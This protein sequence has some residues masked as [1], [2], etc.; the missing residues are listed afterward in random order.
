MK[1]DTLVAATTTSKKIFTK[2]MYTGV[3][4]PVCEGASLFLYK[5]S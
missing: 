3:G 1:L 2:Y 4:H 5:S